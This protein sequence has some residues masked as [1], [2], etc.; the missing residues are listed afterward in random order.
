M[1]RVMI[2]VLFLIACKRFCIFIPFFAS[3]RNS[4]G[5]HMRYFK[6]QLAWTLNWCN[7][8][9]H[10]E[11]ITVIESSTFWKFTLPR[12]YFISTAVI[13]YTPKQFIE[14]YVCIKPQ[15]HHNRTFQMIWLTWNIM[16]GTPF[17]FLLHLGRH[18]LECDNFLHAK[19]R[20]LLTI[21]CPN[22]LEA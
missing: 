11:P 4:F 22:C 1:N 14:S 13:R 5:A 16:Y 15:A 2:H 21:S 17:D 8:L 3:W 9:C 10:S 19:W 20:E 18:I 12:I 6:A 7:V